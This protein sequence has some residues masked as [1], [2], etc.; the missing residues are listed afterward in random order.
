MATYAA[1]PT[2]SQTSLHSES[3]WRPYSAPRWEEVNTF[4]YTTDVTKLTWRVS[5]ESGGVSAPSAATV[6]PG[7]GLNLAHTAVVDDGLCF[8]DPGQT[9]QI[10]PNA[11]FTGFAFWA[12]DQPEELGWAFG[13]H[14]T[15]SA[16][17]LASPQDGIFVYSALGATAVSIKVYKANT[18]TATITTDAVIGTD[19]AAITLGINCDA[20]G[21]AAISLFVNG[22]KVKL[23]G[24][25]SDAV[26]VAAASLPTG[27]LQA[28]G[29]ILQPASDAVAWNWD[30][31]TVGTEGPTRYSGGTFGFGDDTDSGSGSGGGTSSGG[32]PGYDDVPL[33]V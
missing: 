17:T 32:G 5:G 2:G 12:L 15:E 22:F 26:T 28:Y 33:G 14:T 23:N 16:V 13:Y 19:P 30:L 21:N 20:D 6:N 8:F 25:D 11:S 9:I 18:N 1:N 27:V 3:G 31:L 24:G 10:K 7:G 29:E 4:R